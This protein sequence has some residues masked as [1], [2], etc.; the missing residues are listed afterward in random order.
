MASFTD[1]DRLLQELKNKQRT[2]ANQLN[3][4][5]G[6]ING[7]ISQIDEI[8]TKIEDAN[9]CLTLV[10][11][12]PGAINSVTSMLGSAGAQAQAGIFIDGNPVGGNISTS[13]LTISGSIESTCSTM[14]TK[15]MTF[16]EEQT[17]EGNKIKTKADEEKENFDKLLRQAPIDLGEYGPAPMCPVIPT[18]KSIGE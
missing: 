15:I 14:C 6:T 11:S 2:K 17:T 13:S 12:I 16:A 3:G 5:V 8:N 18:V 9:S 1:N 10:R 4:Y 7:Y